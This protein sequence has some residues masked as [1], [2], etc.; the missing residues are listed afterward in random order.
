MM[1]AS[2]P[3]P[4]FSLG[5]CEA[6]GRAVVAEVRAR[7]WPRCLKPREKGLGCPDVR[8][9]SPLGGGTR[10]RRAMALSPEPD[11]RLDRFVL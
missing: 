4:A 8:S 6:D 10:L 7:R 2:Q 5:T 9:T 11:R 1:C 3:A